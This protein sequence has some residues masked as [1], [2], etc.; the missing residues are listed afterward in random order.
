MTTQFMFKIEPK[1]KKAAMKK[2]KEE[3]ITFSAFL[4]FA[5]MAFIEGR[6]NVGLIVKEKPNQR[7]Q[8]II[9]K[10]KSDFRRGINIS[11]A[12]S[13]DKDMDKYLN[14]FK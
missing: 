9:Q 12:F 5:T 10:A 3:G 7:T 4:I 8:K 14:S 11:P 13:N 1:L 6:L 2:A